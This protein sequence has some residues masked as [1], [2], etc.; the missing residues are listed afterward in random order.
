MQAIEPLGACSCL[1]C[2]LEPSAEWDTGSLDRG[3]LPAAVVAAGMGSLQSSDLELPRGSVLL[4]TLEKVA[5]ELQRAP[6]AVSPGA[7]P[8][9]WAL[10]SDPLTRWQ[11]M[12]TLLGLLEAPAAQGEG[13]AFRAVVVPAGQLATMGELAWALSQHP[14]ARFLVLLQAG[15]SLPP[16]SLADVASFL[17]GGERICC[18]FLPLPDFRCFGD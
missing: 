1:Y 10:C 9:H 11:L 5:Q 15:D 2:C 4:T 18:S 12:C 3:T 7:P 8:H 6:K 13:P 17:S 14:R 16:S